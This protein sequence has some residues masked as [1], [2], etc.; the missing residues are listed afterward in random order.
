[1]KYDYEY[2]SCKIPDFDHSFVIGKTIMNRFLYCISIG[3]GEKTAVFAAAFHGLEYLTAPALLSFA[4]YYSE[5]YEYH[6]RLR[7][8]IV[9]MVNPDGVDIVLNGINPASSVHRQLLKDTGI[10]DFSR[11][12]QANAM[13]VDINHNFNADWDSIYKKPMPSKYGGK[14]PE[15]ELETRA[16]TKL[17]RKVQP[18]LFIAFHSQ[19][20]EIYYDF[21]G[22]EN[23]D[24]EKTAGAI[25]AKCGY[26]AAAPTG[27]AAFGGAKDWYIKEYHKQAFTVELGE[28]KNPL[29]V[30]Q[31]DEM[32]RDTRIICMTAID[33]VFT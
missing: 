3:T 15:S 4:E 33:A 6:D 1:M 2:I 29:P 5:Q 19:G 26:R 22:M 25:A 11:Q 27:T 21:N 13:G 31:L 32:K 30:S 14:Y 9:P 7:V 28:G 24:A 18:D 12:W 10:A 17:L 16:M 20:K 23:K 8:F